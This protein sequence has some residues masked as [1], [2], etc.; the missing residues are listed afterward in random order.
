MPREDELRISSHILIKYYI[1]V[2]LFQINHRVSLTLVVIRVSKVILTI[3]GTH[4]IT[5]PKLYRAFSLKWLQLR[6]ITR[7]PDLLPRIAR[8]TQSRHVLHQKKLPLE[9]SLL[10]TNWDLTGMLHHKRRVLFQTQMTTMNSTGRNRALPGTILNRMKTN[11]TT[12]LEN[13]MTK[14]KSF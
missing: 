1:S 4:L 3:Q 6:R 8:Q 12:A 13:M 14:I 11:S 9:K 2:F 10:G 7:I 5:S